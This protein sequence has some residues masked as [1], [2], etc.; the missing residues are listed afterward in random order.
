MEQ[1]RT[2]E[3]RPVEILSCHSGPHTELQT[4]YT[5]YKDEGGHTQQSSAEIGNSK[6]GI[7]GS[8]I[9]TTTL[10]LC[11]SVDLYSTP[12]WARSHHTHVL[13]SE[14]NTACRAITGCLKPT[15]VEDPYLLD[16]IAPPDIRRDVCARV[17]KKQESNVAHSLYGQTQTESRLKSRSCFLS[18][19]RPAD[20]HQKIIRCNEWKHRLNTKTHSCSANLTESLARGHTSQW[21]TWRCLNRL[22]TGVTCSKEQRKKWGYYEGDTKCDCGVSSENTR[23]S[24]SLDD[25]LQFNKQQNRVQTNEIQR[26]DDRMK[27][28]V[29]VSVYCARRI[30]ANLRC[31]QCSILLHLIDICFLTCI[32][33]W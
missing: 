1:Y 11:Y 2:R 8:T 29:Q 24:C 22:R 31:T 33:L 26:F 4:A 25:L 28:K 7:S 19:V 20:L 17:E 9:R 15:N 30:P 14:L 10:A 16:G 13:D 21:T 12:V 32:C 23:H 5:Q 6:W 27:K 3:H 18:S